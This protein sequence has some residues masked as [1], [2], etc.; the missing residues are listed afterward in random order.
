MPP[1]RVVLWHSVAATPIA[2]VVVLGAFLSYHYHVLSNESRARVDLGYETLD[3]VQAVFVAIED[4]NVAEQEFIITGDPS[5]LASFR[6]ALV[7]VNEH[8]KA[9]A[10]LLS[11]TRRQK[12]QLAGLQQAIAGNLNE[13]AR[14]IELRRSKGFDAARADLNMRVGADASIDRVREA[15]RALAATEREL[16]ARRQQ[17]QG[18]HE[19][20]VLLIGVLIAGLSVVTRIAI[21]LSLR[22]MRKERMPARRAS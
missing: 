12:E 19:Q 17:A 5:F 11:G 22:R 1:R 10:R 2:I 8:S 20:D 7:S 3:D 21:A 9:L 6:A 14:G 13:L 4:A 16:L 15:A 18:R